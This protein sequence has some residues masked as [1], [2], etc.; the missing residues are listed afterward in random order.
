MVSISKDGRRAITACWVMLMW[1][2]V[3]EASSC[4]S[5]KSKALILLRDNE[6][7]AL[8]LAEDEVVLDLR[9]SMI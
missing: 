3:M 9:R 6:V 4:L 2:N 7:V 1:V 5:S 8:A